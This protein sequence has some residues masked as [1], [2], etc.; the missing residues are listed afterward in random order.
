MEKRYLILFVLL[1]FGCNKKDDYEC[2]LYKND[3]EIN[4]D[5]IG[6]RNII[7][8]INKTEI[9]ILDE[10][11]LLIDENIKLIDEQFQEYP[12]ELIDNKIYIKRN[13]QLDEEYNLNKSIDELRKSGFSC[14]KR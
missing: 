14:V 7:E 9:I 4:L 11:V 1:L 13:I 5:I 8:N 6:K 12:Y 3:I 10:E 2:S